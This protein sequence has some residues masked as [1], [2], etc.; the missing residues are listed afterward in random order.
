MRQ[1]I[2]IVTVFVINGC[3]LLSDF[4]GYTFEQQY[5]L[6][7]GA[8]GARS[9]FDGFAG[10]GGEYLAG[11]GGEIDLGGAGGVDEPTAGAGGQDEPLAGAGGAGGQDE[12]AAGAGG[13]GGVGGQDEPFAGA[14]GQAGVGGEPDP[15][16]VGGVGDPETMQCQPCIDDTDCGNELK[17]GAV[18]RPLRADGGPMVCLVRTGGACD[19]DLVKREEDTMCVG[20]MCIGYCVPQDGD[21]AAWLEAH[22]Y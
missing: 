8:A 2:A 3:S 1:I 14:G 4:G 6:D 5:A 18:C 19:Y 16:G 12:P 22:G 20:S 9:P 7:A 10:A 13:V 17:E 15:G 21:C 11:A